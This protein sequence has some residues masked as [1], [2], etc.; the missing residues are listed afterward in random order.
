MTES[1]FLRLLRFKKISQDID[2]E[3]LVS[4]LTQC[5]GLQR[6]GPINHLSA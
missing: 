3:L 4:P 2:M 5:S 1:T 6:S